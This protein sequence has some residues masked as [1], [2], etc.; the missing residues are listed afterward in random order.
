[1]KSNFGFWREG[2]QVFLEKTSRCR[3]ENQ[4]T[5]PTFDARSWESN[6]GHTGGR[7]VLSPLRHPCTPN[8]TKAKSVYNTQVTINLHLLCLLIF[9]LQCYKDVN[10]FIIFKHQNYIHYGRLKWELLHFYWWHHSF[11]LSMLCFMEDIKS[12][13][14]GSCLILQELN[15]EI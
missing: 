6:P 2:K 7:R 9:E 14:T 15:E 10:K 12:T 8:E 3:V 5:Q 1:M 13:R 4:Q 11:P